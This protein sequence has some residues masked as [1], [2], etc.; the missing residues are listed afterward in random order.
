MYFHIYIN[1]N[2]N[3][4]YCSIQNQYRNI[5]KENPKFILKNGIIAI[6]GPPKDLK[7][8]DLNFITFFT[9]FP[10]TYTRIN[11]KYIA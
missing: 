4:K 9:F 3:L 7:C 10:Y 1:L 8:S 6:S 11:Y 5:Y 2:Y